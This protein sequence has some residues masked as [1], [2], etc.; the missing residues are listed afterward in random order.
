VTRAQLAVIQV[1]KKWL[2]AKDVGF[3]EAAY[4]ELLK[5]KGGVDS[6][7]QLDAAGFEAVMA[8]FTAW[9]FNSTWRQR[10]FGERPGM[11]SPKQIL[12]VRALWREY[13]GADDESA[14]NKWLGH[15]HGVSA[16]RFATPAVA[17]NAIAALKDMKARKAAKSAEPPAAC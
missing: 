5:L 1:A 13:T 10:T 8:Y 17:R 3:D 9:G 14:L 16:L 12:L 11:A 6:S 7:T 15:Y 2:V 4:R